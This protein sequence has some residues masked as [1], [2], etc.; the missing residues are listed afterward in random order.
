M[1]CHDQHPVL[2]IYI[3]LASV[4]SELVKVTLLHFLRTLKFTKK[5]TADVTF[6]CIQKYCSDISVRHIAEIVKWH[7][8]TPVSVTGIPH[9]FPTKANSMTNLVKGRARC[10]HACG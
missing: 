6:S 8:V 10:M 2:L 4:G 7:A 3:S 5:F 9:L 1:S